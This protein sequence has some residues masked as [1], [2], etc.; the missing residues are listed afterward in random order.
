MLCKTETAT[1]PDFRPLTSANGGFA[2]RESNRQNNTKF[3]FSSLKYAN[4]L[5][6]TKYGGLT[7]YKTEIS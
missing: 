4:E 3:E 2:T 5:G 6:E 7:I 1:E